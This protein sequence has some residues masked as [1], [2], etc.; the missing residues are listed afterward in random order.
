MKRTPDKLA[1]KRWGLGLWFGAV[2]ALSLCGWGLLA[3]G[4]YFILLAA[5]SA[6]A[7]PEAFGGVKFLLTS[8]LICS[9]SGTLGGMIS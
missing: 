2:C 6:L 5:V 4:A 1:W 9:C 8:L 7:V 3:G